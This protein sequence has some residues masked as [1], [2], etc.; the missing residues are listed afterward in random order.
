MTVVPQS[1]GRDEGDAF[2]K[3]DES[4]MLHKFQEAG[5]GG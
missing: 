5:I 1:D 2:I 4:L 3:L